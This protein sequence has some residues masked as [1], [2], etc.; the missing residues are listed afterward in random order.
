MTK[1]FESRCRCAF[2]DHVHSDILEQVA[3]NIT[4]TRIAE[5]TDSSECGDKGLQSNL[6][7][8]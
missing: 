8:S 5:F 4:N 6:F 2:F 1:G 3:S 7:E